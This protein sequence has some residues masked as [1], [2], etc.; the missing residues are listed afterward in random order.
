MYL[1]PGWSGLY[2]AGLAPCRSMD[3]LA[4][5][6]GCTGVGMAT[7]ALPIEW[8]NDGLFI[9]RG[10]VTSWSAVLKGPNV[11]AIRLV[12]AIHFGEFSRM[13]E[14]DVAESY[15]GNRTTTRYLVGG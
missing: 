3:G 9:P 2:P 10:E 1:S 14:V 15:G 12:G 13:V 11:A 5:C 7:R 8:H 6:R 4:V